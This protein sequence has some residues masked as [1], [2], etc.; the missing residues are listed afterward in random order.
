MPEIPAVRKHTYPYP[1]PPMSSNDI[2]NL[3]FE[4]AGGRGLAY[5][6]VIDRLPSYVDTTRVKR[7]GGTSAGAIAAFLLSIGCSACRIKMLMEQLSLDI[8]REGLEAHYF[9]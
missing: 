5:A 6:G 3:A 4:G 7:Y 2:K 8:I 1:N 9:C